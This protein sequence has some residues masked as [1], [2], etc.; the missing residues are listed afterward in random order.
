MADMIRI[1]LSA[2]QKSALQ[3]CARAQR[4]NCQDVVM[5]ALSTVLAPYMG[6]TD[7]RS[8]S[9]TKKR[10]LYPEPVP[11]DLTADYLDDQLLRRLAGRHPP[12]D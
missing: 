9:S 10:D 7:S 8:T 11:N 1:R 6:D 12:P 5:S 4:L 2:K 3:A